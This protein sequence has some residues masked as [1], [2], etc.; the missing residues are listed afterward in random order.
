MVSSCLKE[1]GGDAS[2]R[3]SLIS[4][5]DVVEQLGDGPGDR[6]KEDHKHPDQSRA[7]RTDGETIS[8][9]DLIP[10]SLM[11]LPTSSG[12]AHRL[13]D[14][15]AKD[16]NHRSGHDDGSNSSAE[17]VVQEDRQRLVDDL[18]LASVSEL[19]RALWFAAG[20]RMKA[21]THDIAQ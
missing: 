4:A 18:L 10:V 9:T 2:S 7:R 12:E 13:R 1:T 17:N 21:T 15:F 19:R 5:Q 8:D 3:V 6:R 11:F 16:D 20:F 14:D